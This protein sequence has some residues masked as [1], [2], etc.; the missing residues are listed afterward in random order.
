MKK[1]VIFIIP[2]IGKGGAERVVV[3]IANQMVSDGYNVSI[4]TILSKEENYKLADGVNH[5]HLNVY[6]RN[7]L[8]RMIKRFIKLRYMVKHSNADTVI[9][10]DR[11]YGI[12]SALFTG[13]RVIGSE[14]NDPYSN[15]PANS[16]QKHIRDWLYRHIDCVVFQTEYAQNYFSDR[17]KKH[18]TVI[19]NP[20]STDI[21]PAPF[22]GTRD[23][24]I[25]TACRLTEQ[26]NLP[27]M[28]DAFSL[29]SQVHKGYQL[30]IYGEGHLLD[31]LKKYTVEREVGNQVIFP[32]Y[33]NNLPEKI[34]SAAMYVSSS[35]YEGISNAML[36]ALAIGLP[37][38]CTDC[39]AGGS[40]M[41][42]RNGE[43]GYLVPVNQAE[44]MAKAMCQ[45]IEN[46]ARTHKMSQKA[47]EVRSTF[48]IQ[49]IT[50]QWENIL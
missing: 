48:C 33:V 42:I 43:N 44:E 30:V 15:M 18:S 50:K 7:K 40:A 6:D 34:N 38:V 29:F 14:R 21:L 35:D 20:V 3:N 47:I 2:R 11:Y 36:E 31:S 13:K 16:F 5:V 23:K 45:V 27:M 12:F 49:E 9:A 46:K 39:P 1:K 17:I 41:V 37:V 25:V 24:R 26:K 19:S 28:I 32:G 4:F 8:L 22:T 10:F